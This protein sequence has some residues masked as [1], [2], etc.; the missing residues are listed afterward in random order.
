MRPRDH[1]ESVWDQGRLHSIRTDGFRADA[2]LSPASD[3]GPS[4][5]TWSLNSL[6]YS[7]GRLYNRSLKEVI[8]IGK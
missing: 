1:D 4:G 2:G 7:D 3:L 6:S 8:C 5:E